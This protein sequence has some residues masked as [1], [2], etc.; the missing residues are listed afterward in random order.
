M[1]NILAEFH[2]GVS[3]NRHSVYTGDGNFKEERAGRTPPFGV[4]GDSVEVLSAPVGPSKYLLYSS[5][6]A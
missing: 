6:L 2:V 4:D 1:G 5:R 3:E